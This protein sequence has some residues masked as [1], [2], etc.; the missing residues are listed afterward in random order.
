MKEKN[1]GRCLPTW[2]R[3][4]AVRLVGNERVR[5]VLARQITRQDSARHD[6][7]WYVLHAVNADV[8]VLVLRFRRR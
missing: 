6:P 1:N 3:C 7:G 8:Y 5:G 2:E 4:D